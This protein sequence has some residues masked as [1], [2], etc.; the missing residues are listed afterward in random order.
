[1]WKILVILLGTLGT[2]KVSI[3]LK[4]KTIFDTKE[5]CLQAS[6]REDITKDILQFSNILKSLGYT[7]ISI[8]KFTCES[9]DASL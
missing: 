3:D 1:M 5:L 2:D 6:L 9:V 7:D 4:S 8:Q